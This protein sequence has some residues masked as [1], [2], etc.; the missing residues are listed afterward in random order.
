MKKILV[1]GFIVGSLSFAQTS[2]ESIQNIENVYK[3]LE[4]EYTLLMKKEQE[5]YNIEKQVADAARATLAKQQT[6]YNEL[7]NKIA[8]LNKIK[9]TRFYK[10]SYEKLAKEYSTI[11]AKLDKQMAIS[12]QAIARFDA[13]KAFRDSRLSK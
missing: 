8:G 13:I 2:Q 12:K 11:L 7:S 3:N 6:M 9:D 4:Q 10:D 5:Q 1:L